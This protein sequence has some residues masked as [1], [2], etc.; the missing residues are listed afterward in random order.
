M[1]NR[2]GVRLAVVALL[3]AGL[4]SPATVVA[5]PQNKY[6]GSFSYTALPDPIDNWDTYRWDHRWDIRTKA[7]GKPAGGTFTLRQYVVQHEFV[8]VTPT[9][10]NQ[11]VFRVTTVKRI[12]PTTIEFYSPGSF[13]YSENEAQY[14]CT[15]RWRVVGSGKSG[16]LWYEC[17]AHDTYHPMSPEA[18]LAH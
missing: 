7:A 5:R 2:T 8:D 10:K 3:V 13:G 12:D 6:R 15:G 1:N 11:W 4:I 17:A 14:Y 18:I 16:E 9:L